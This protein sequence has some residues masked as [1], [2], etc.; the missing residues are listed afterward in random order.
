MGISDRDLTAEQQLAMEQAYQ[1]KM[2]A[3]RLPGWLG[4]LDITQL[5]AVSHALKASLLHRQQLA[6]RLAGLQPI[7]AFV[8]RALNRALAG[9]YEREVDVDLLYLRQW[10]YYFTEKPTWAT[11]R[12]P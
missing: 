5:D 9:R 7:D 10:Y 2:I 8:K 3:N 12:W 4:R 1:D 11:G 6:A